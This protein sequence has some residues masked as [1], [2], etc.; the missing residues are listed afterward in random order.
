MLTKR[1]RTA[2]Y[3]Q[4]EETQRTRIDNVRRA[5]RAA[6][7]WEP[8]GRLTGQNP[9]FLRQMCGD[10]AQRAIGERLARKLEFDLGVPKGWLD[11]RH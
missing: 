3:K 7:G 11:I 2:Y 6:G 1:D 9:M 5:M 4:I 8:L 10:Y